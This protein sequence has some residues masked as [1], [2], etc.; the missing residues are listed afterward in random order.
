MKSVLRIALLLLKL[1]LGI[2]LILG[3]L[4]GIYLNMHDAIF[5]ILN[6]VALMIG[7]SLFM[8]PLFPSTTR[9]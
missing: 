7:V 8:T 9:Y 3:G 6:T 1:L 4:L 2:A 5:L